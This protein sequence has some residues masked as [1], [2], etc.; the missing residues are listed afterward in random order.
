[1]FQS[2]HLS[3][4]F[5]ILVFFY[6]CFSFC[7][8]VSITF[9][10]SS[11]IS[12]VCIPLAHKAIRIR[13][14]F[15]YLFLVLQ[16]TLSA[17]LVFFSLTLFFRSSTL[18]HVPCTVHAFTVFYLEFGALYSSNAA[19]AMK[20]S[21]TQCLSSSSSFFKFFFIFYRS[22]TDAH[23]SMYLSIFLFV[24]ETV[25]VCKRHCLGNGKFFVENDNENEI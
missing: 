4:C 12:V 25:N 20:H 2:I 18:L 7:F 3:V 19:R 6:F 22:I 24:G 15:L 17:L 23:V 21:L 9:L 13:S 8:D 16:S 1:M 5:R 11:S 14:A 10:V